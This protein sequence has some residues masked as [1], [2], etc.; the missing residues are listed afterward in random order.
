MYCN[1]QYSLHYLKHDLIYCTPG[2]PA[3]GR[4]EADLRLHHRSARCTRRSDRRQKQRHHL[5][6]PHDHRALEERYRMVYPRAQTLLPTVSCLHYAYECFEGLKAYSGDDGKLRLF[7]P[8]RNGARLQISAERISLPPAPSEELKKLILALLHVDA[9][10]WPRD[11]ALET[12]SIYDPQSSART[13]SSVCKRP[14]KPCCILL[15]AICRAW[16]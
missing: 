15:L 10:K 3:H 6:P 5:H 4:I 8:D 7:R 2:H 11:I 12:S 9:V 13:Y 16:I 1:D 14:R